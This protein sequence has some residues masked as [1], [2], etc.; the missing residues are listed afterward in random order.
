MHV[1]NIKTAKTIYII[2][3]FVHHMGRWLIRKTLSR[4]KTTFK[5]AHNLN[6]EI[7]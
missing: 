5:G 1:E 3:D 6:F 4:V 2:E 7:S